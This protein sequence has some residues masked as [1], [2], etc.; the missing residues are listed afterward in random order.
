MSA[1]SNCG[2]QAGPSAQPPLDEGGGRVEAPEAGEIRVPGLGQ[3]PAL[4]R[5]R[6]RIE[7]RA[8]VADRD[9]AVAPPCNSRIGALT[10]PMRDS[11]WMRSMTM[12]E[13]DA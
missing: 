13:T 2:E 11:E 8:A 4:L 6:R 7:Q 1:K 12:W 10:S 9:D 3:E 5:L